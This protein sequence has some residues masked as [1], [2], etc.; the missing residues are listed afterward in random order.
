[1]SGTEDPI[2]GE[3]AGTAPARAL[4]EREPPVAQ[5][6]LSGGLMNAVVL[7]LIGASVGVFWREVFQLTIRMIE[8]L[9]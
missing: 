7:M 1:M 9:R 3:A 8:E 2:K 4:E 6:R 5:S